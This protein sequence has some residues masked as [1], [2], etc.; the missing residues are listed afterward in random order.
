[1]KLS[2]L[3]MFGLLVA[4]AEAAAV[5]TFSADSAPARP[6]ASVFGSEAL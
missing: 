4:E 3:V 1:M 5:R 6:L 2:V